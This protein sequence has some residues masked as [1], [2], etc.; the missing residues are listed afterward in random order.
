MH[1]LSGVKGIALGA[2]DDRLP[3]L[4]RNLGRIQ[5]GRDEEAS[6]LVCERREID[7]VHVGQ[8][9]SE[10]GTALE[11][12]RARG[13]DD[14]QRNALGPIGQVLEEGEQPIVSPVQILEHEDGR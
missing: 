9:G 12:L 4:S 3:Q 10:R 6:L 2:L 1:E 5:Q 13:A 7:A 8:S 11:E 14:E